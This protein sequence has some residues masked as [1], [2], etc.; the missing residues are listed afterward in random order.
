MNASTSATR[1]T[2]DPVEESK[3]LDRLSDSTDY[4]VSLDFSIERWEAHTRV[5]VPAKKETHGGS[6]LSTSGKPHD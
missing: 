5:L 3:R 6:G 1:R 4:S 2:G